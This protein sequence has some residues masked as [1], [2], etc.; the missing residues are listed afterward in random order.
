MDVQKLMKQAQKMQA[1]LV[2]AQEEIAAMTFE[3]TSGGGALKAITTGDNRL[4]SLTIS[5][6]VIKDGDAEM[7]SD[8]ILTAVNS[9]LDSAKKH[10]Q[11]RMASLTG[12]LGLPGF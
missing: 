11:E 9:A 10:T 5:P 7:L 4:K 3:G 8:L 12:G 2:K 1:N 6:D